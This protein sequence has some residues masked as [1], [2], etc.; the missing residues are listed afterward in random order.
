MSLM[1]LDSSAHH[2]SRVVSEIEFS[3]SARGRED[4][5][6]ISGYTE[7]G[8]VG[9]SCKSRHPSAL[10]DHRR[11]KHTSLSD[12]SS[13]APGVSWESRVSLPGARRSFAFVSDKTNA[14]AAPYHLVIRRV[15]KG[16]T[17]RHRRSGMHLRSQPS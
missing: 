15:V 14:D 10:R 3:V 1:R 12:D 17:E 16:A 8:H 5:H 13:L 6:N 9:S 7:R 2:T 11:N 4:T